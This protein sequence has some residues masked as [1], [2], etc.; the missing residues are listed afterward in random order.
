[1]SSLFSS[2]GKVLLK[3]SLSDS[4]GAM[5]GNTRSHKTTR[6]SYLYSC[7]TDEDKRRGLSPMV[8]SSGL[9]KP[10]EASCIEIVSGE[11]LLSMFLAVFRF[12]M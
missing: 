1:M 7:S 3:G 8:I 11:P 4:E 2:S 10:T 5:D 6:K 9:A 12:L